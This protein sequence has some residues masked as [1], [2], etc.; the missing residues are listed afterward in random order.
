LEI[1]QRPGYVAVWSASLNDKVPRDLGYKNPGTPALRML[2]G[3][4]PG[5]TQF[6][7]ESMD[8]LLSMDP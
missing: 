5:P 8:Q 4:Q 2:P 1:W 6:L 3:F 7:N